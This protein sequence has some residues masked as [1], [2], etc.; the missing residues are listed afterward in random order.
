MLLALAQRGQAGQGEHTSHSHAFS[1]PPKRADIGGVAVHHATPVIVSEPA[2]QHE[3]STFSPV[4]RTKTRFQ[5]T[6]ASPFV[7][8]TEGGYAEEEKGEF[9]DLHSSV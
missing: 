6:H 1:S 3:L 7:I 5:N 9:E 2:G 4:G 8:G